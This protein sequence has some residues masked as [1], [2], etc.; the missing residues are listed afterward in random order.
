M[1]VVPLR[2]R[3][4]SLLQ[5][6]AMDRTELSPIFLHPLKSRYFMLGLYVEISSTLASLMCIQSARASPSKWRHLRTKIEIQLFFI[7]S[8]KFYIS[9]G[10]ESVILTA[11][12]PLRS[13]NLSLS[14]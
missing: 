10:N 3:F 6:F 11:F 14:Q 7:Y 9:V 13:M 8:L 1:T 5:K 12:I 2:F 4:S